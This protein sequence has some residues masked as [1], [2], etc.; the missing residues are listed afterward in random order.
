MLDDTDLAFYFTSHSEATL[1]AGRAVADVWSRI[2]TLQLINHNTNLAEPVF[3][4]ERECTRAK[5]KAKYLEDNPVEPPEKKQAVA[6]AKWKAGGKSSRAVD[7]TA[8]D[9]DKSKFVPVLIDIMTRAEALKPA[10]DKANRQATKAAWEAAL[11]RRAVVRVEKSEKETLTRVQR[12]WE[13]LSS[14]A[15]RGNLHIA[16]LGVV[17]LESF[18]YEGEAQAREL[19]ALRWMKNNLYLKWPIHDLIQPAKSGPV[20]HYSSQATCAEPA[21]VARLSSSW[22]EGCCHL[23]R[24]FVLS[25]LPVSTALFALL[26]GCSTAAPNA[27]ITSTRSDPPS[28]IFALTQRNAPEN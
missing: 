1:N 6:K 3:E 20:K 26:Q 16:E 27:S 13:E 8:K 24:T 19:A 17:S 22:P 11:H 14:F 15:Q 10:D 23:T 18:L 7:N 28:R 9:E 12:T 25:K 2:R 5:R 4:K 21:M